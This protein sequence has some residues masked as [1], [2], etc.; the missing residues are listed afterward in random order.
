MN[1]EQ[2]KQVWAIYKTVSAMPA[3]D[4]DSHVRSRTDDA[5]VAGRVLEML[6]KPESGL[7]G[8]SLESAA[9]EIN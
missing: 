8:R 9:E 7:T 4:W 5:Q 3:A 1:G 2:W 6:S